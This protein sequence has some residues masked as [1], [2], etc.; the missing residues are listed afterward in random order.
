MFL[1]LPNSLV[2]SPDPAPDPSFSH[3]SVQGIEIMVA[4]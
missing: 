4:K 2:T 1:G 3:E